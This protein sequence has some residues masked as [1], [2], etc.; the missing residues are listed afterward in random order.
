V[1]NREQAVCP[2]SSHEDR[3][4][5]WS[6][7]ARRCVRVARIEQKFAVELLESS[8]NLLDAQA[9]YEACLT[10]ALLMKCRRSALAAMECHRSLTGV[11][12]R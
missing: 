7:R 8:K 2:E 12:D 9:L 11:I 3:L 6:R 4:L 5:F 10:S 1:K